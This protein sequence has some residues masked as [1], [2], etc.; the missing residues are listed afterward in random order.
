MVRPSGSKGFGAQY[1]NAFGDRDESSKPYRG[2]VFV[3]VLA[4]GLF[5]A[6]A[7]HAAPGINYQNGLGNEIGLGDHGSGKS[8][9]VKAS[10]ANSQALAINTGLNLF[11]ESPSFASAKGDGATAVSI[12]GY[13][14][15]T[16]ANSHGFAAHTAWCGCRHQK[17]AASGK[18]VICPCTRVPEKETS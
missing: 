6:G 9:D 12:D 17:R 2:A 14:A 11:S 8:A 10:G 18:L 4:A 3:G 16:G 15:V 5:G 13:T 1:K 7:A